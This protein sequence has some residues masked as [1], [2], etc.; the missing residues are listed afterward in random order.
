MNNQKLL[1]GKGTTEVIK[2]KDKRK[3]TIEI[4]ELE[5]DNNSDENLKNWREKNIPIPKIKGYGVDFL[6]HNEGSASPCDNIEEARKRVADLKERYG[7]KYKLEVK[8]EL[9]ILIKSQENVNVEEETYENS[10]WKEISEMIKRCEKEDEPYYYIFVNYNCKSSFEGVKDEYL[11]ISESLT[12]RKDELGSMSGGGGS[13]DF[14]EEKDR[15]EFKERLIF[16]R[17]SVCDKPYTKE[18]CVNKGGGSD[19]F[20]TDIKKENTMVSF[21]IKAKEFCERKGFSIEEFYKEFNNFEQKPAT[22][23]D[24]TKARTFEIMEKQVDKLK[25]ECY[26]IRNYFENFLNKRKEKNPYYLEQMKKYNIDYS[27]LNKLKELYDNKV[28]IYHIYYCKVYE[29][30]WNTP[31]DEDYSYP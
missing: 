25:D 4:K 26:A 13:Y 20:L 31:C 12:R 29:M 23:E 3:G 27:D 6:G 19:L 8:D 15:K 11:S 28:K 14:K 17:K 10:D 9:G 30:R 22:K 7:G 18:C 5:F 16:I 2:D 21:S 1:F 24:L